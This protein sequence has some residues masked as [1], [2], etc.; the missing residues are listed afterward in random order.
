MKRQTHVKEGEGE[1][2]REKDNGDYIKKTKGKVKKQKEGDDNVGG[3]S[4]V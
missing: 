2:A 3:L 4:M 1:R